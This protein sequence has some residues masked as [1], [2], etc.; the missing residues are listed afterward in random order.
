MI[1][2]IAYW[3]KRLKSLKATIEQ[4]EK[5]IMH[6]DIYR[7]Q[8]ENQDFAISIR[9][10]YRKTIGICVQKG[11][12]VV[13]TA[14]FG[15]D[16]AY[17][18]SVIQRKS[19]WIAQKITEVE[20]YRSME[21]IT[22]YKSGQSLK[23]LGRDYTIKVMQVPDFEEEQII[24]EPKLVKVYV[25]DRTQQERI[26]LL[27][28]DW[29]RNSALLYLSQKF[30]ECYEKIKKYKIKKPLYYLRNMKNRWGSCT[31]KGTILLNPEIF[32]LPSHCIEYIILHE[33][34][35]LK[36]HNH[37]PRFYRFLDT[38]LPEWKDRAKALDS[39]LQS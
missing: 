36:H 15:T 34:C 32:Q 31:S 9:Y 28:E 2:W 4:K 38:V 17:I 3:M 19:R 33:L 22:E 35:H 5:E 8:H 18:K 7:F 37:S 30:E 20:R 27:I 26:H 39:F 23:I 11:K 13:V 21:P 24:Q 29:Y 12:K 10:S 14:P 1:P 6:R 16:F 25:Y